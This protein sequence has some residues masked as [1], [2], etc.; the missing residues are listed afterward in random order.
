ML[1]LTLTT[2][3]WLVASRGVLRTACETVAHRADGRED[4]GDVGALG[5][6]RSPEVVQEDREQEAF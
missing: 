1:A 3:C 4:G 6:R 2:G 5:Q